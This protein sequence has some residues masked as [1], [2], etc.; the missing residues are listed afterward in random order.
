MGYEGTDLTQDI[1]IDK[2]YTVHYF[3]Y[4]KSYTYPGEAHDFWECGYVDR[5]E[6]I[7]TAGDREIRLARGEILFH[8]PNEWHTLRANGIVAPNLVVL[9]FS[10]PSP[11]MEAFRSLHA[12]VG[13]R[14]RELIA[15]ILR[16]SEAVFS[17]PL[18]DPGTTKME[19]H[20]LPPI[21]AEQLIRSYLEELLI[22]LLRSEP[23]KQISPLRH[24]IEG[25]LFLQLTDYMQK[26]LAFPVSLAELAHY[27]GVSESTV[28]AVFRTRAGMGATAYFIRMRID[29]AKAYIREGNYNLTQIA[30]LL[31]Y[32][33][34]HYFSRQFRTV[35]GMAPSEYARSVR[36]LE[37]NE[38]ADEKEED[39][40]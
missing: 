21:G 28:K 19:K 34:I 14:A 7:A 18:G 33:S 36:A 20:E 35:T 3:E 13:Q 15:G 37:K 29:T 26:N 1:A 9:S 25:D 39:A 16:E 11:A 38:K 31:G 27:A 17:T 10:C 23:A 32:D 22:L 30:E 12:H 5:G 2:L 24:R 4:S 40:V 6:I 8:E